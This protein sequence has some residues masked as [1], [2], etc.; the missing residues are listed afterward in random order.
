MNIKE[1]IK[2]IFFYR[3]HPDAALR[4]LPIVDILKKHGLAKSR[5]LEIGSGSYGITPY[6]GRKITGIDTKF[7][8]P[9]HELLTQV[10]MSAIKIPFKSNEFDVAIFSDVLEHI[11]KINRIK[12]LNEVIRVTRKALVISGPFGKDSYSQDK[13]LAKYSK[14]KLKKTHPF[15]CEHLK[16]GLPEI[17]DIY[18]YLRKQPRVKEIKVEGQSLNLKVR[19]WLMKFFITNNKLQFYFYL[20]GLMVFVPLLRKM[21]SKPCYRQLIYVELKEDK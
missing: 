5:I 15:F 13:K 16:N 19:E 20:K 8:E 21:N 9:Q 10:K 11:P 1:K 2:R 4:Y 18:T 3:Q 14:Q 12:V 7:D 17:V 6:L